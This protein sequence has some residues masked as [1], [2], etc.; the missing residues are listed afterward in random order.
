MLETPL[1][2]LEGIERVGMSGLLA[3]ST[4][5]D[6]AH[7]QQSQYYGRQGQ[8]ANL[9]HSRVDYYDCNDYRRSEIGFKPGLVILL[10]PAKQRG[11]HECLSKIN[12]F[13]IPGG[14]SFGL[15]SEAT[16]FGG[17]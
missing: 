4:V 2:V 13:L 12:A 6:H 17:E 5:A 11:N 14:R 1:V 10:K 3:E 9:Q 16:V 15:H 8:R 7:R